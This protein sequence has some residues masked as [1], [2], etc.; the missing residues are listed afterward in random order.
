[1]KRPKTILFFLFQLLSRETIV[2]LFEEFRILM[3]IKVQ[4]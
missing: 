2:D 3:T 4:F 1:M